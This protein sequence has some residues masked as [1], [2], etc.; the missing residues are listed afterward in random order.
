MNYNTLN[1]EN[2]NVAYR[3]YLIRFALQRISDYGTAEDLVQDTFLSGWNA[4]EKFRGDC[5]ERTWLT[6]IL[7][8][9]VIDHYRRIGRRPSVLTTDLDSSTEEGESAAWIDRQ[10]DLRLVH[11][12]EAESERN[13]FLAELEEAVDGLPEKMGKAFRMREMQGHLTKDIT[14]E[15]GISKA[16]LWVLI[17]RAKQSL[18]KKLDSHWGGIEQFG[19]KLAA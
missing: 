19:G 3:D 12:P 10:P 18:S 17:H 16:N 9:K 8:N 13:E 4:R 11:R 15:L 7:H 6:G 2:W 14:R 1:P 5:N